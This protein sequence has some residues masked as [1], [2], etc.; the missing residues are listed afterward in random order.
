M[1]QDHEPVSQWIAEGEKGLVILDKTPFYAESGG[2][3][4]DSRIITS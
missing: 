4:G 2:Q 1:L 3:V